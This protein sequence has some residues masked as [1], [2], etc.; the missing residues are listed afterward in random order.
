VPPPR[1]YRSDGLA[2]WERCCLAPSDLL[3]ENDQQHQHE[4]V[5]H[6]TVPPF[7]WTSGIRGRCLFWTAERMADPCR[8]PF[9]ALIPP[10]I[11]QQRRR[12]AGRAGDELDLE[13]QLDVAAV[14]D[15]QRAL[16]MS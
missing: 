8:P 16:P 12:R 9:W 1:V 2:G 14:A 15:L 4:D 10:Q 13:R 5:Q 3:Q 6:R 7:W 11:E